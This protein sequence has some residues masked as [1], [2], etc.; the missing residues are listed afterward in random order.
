[1]ASKLYLYEI[2]TISAACLRFPARALA[3]IAKKDAKTIQ[4]RRLNLQVKSEVPMAC[5]FGTVSGLY[6]SQQLI[7]E[8]FFIISLFPT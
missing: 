2:K 5:L 3:H 1:M 7:Q 8:I 6:Q 4:I